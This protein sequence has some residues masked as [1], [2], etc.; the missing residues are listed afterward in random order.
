MVEDDEILSNELSVGLGLDGF[1]VDALTTCADACA[2]LEVGDFDAALL[3]LMLPDGSGLD[4]LATIRSSDRALPVIML[5][6][7]DA[8]AERIAGLDLGAND[9]VGKP[10]DLGELPARLRAIIRR[11]S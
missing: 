10:F 3:D 9:Y 2:A 5:T 11:A 1:E 7:K 4:I 8:A 6:A